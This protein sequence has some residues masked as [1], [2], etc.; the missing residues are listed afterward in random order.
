MNARVTAESLFVSHF[1]PLYPDDAKADL[2]RARTTDA[3]VANNP[4]ILAE[5][6]DAA[7]V[8]SKMAHG[9]FSAD[10]AL[11]FS[12]ASV[13]R[14]SAAITRELR[15]QWIAQGAAGTSD[16]SLFNIVVHGAL[17][18]G[19][20]VA[21]SHGGLWRVRRPLW[22]SL[23]RLES[24]AGI[25]DL[26]A[27]QWWLKSLSD[28]AF[29]GAQTL[30]DRY[31]THV[32]VPTTNVNAFAKITDEPRTLPRLSTVRYDLLYKYLKA[33]VA[34]I[35]DLGRDFPSP[36]RFDEMAFKWLD[37]ALVGDSRMLLIYGPGESGA[38]LF[39]VSMM[40]FEKSAFYPTDRGSAV[41][42]VARG[43]TIEVTVAIDGGAR[44]HEM[45]WWGG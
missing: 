6:E 43:E 32:E 4:A 34:E 18:I 16:N 11:D 10:L 28:D 14:L 8:F 26:A 36:E 27:F 15:D 22:E 30:A 2:A 40:G 3:N 29:D 33:H 9:V 31:R 25:A 37:F 44:K 13:H 21:R 17:Y 5:A 7:N 20:C 39:W 1:L 19:A 12:D 23:I 35:R 24:R 41:K 45:M 38:H 42:L